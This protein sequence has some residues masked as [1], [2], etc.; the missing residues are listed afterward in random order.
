MRLSAARP[1][2]AT[3]TTARE[4]PTSLPESEA[5]PMRMTHRHLTRSL[6]LLRGGRLALLGLLLLAYSAPGRATSDDKGKGPTKAPRSGEKAAAPKYGSPRD[7]L[8]TLYF[9]IDVYG[10]LPERIDD[11]VACLGEKPSSREEQQVAARLAIQLEAILA[12]AAV[13]LSNLPAK[14]EGDAVVSYDDK[15]LKI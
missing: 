15:E 1:M 11:A 3:A 10:Q 6:P 8:K 9:A 12:V 5:A 4:R 14:P 2:F 7:T 13:P